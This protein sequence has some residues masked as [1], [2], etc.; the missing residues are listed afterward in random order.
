M[1]I[2]ETNYKENSKILDMSLNCK[3]LSDARRFTNR[4]LNYLENKTIN[5]IK[6][7][8]FANFNDKKWE[9]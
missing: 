7:S 4:Q 8:I 9:E 5:D 6:I 2:R 1:G 3:K